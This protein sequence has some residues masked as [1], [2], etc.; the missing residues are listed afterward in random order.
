M[1]RVTIMS[2]A[3][4]ITRGSAAVAE[5]ISSLST[6]ERLLFSQGV[7]QLGTNAW[8]ELAK[9][10]SRHPLM[11]RPKNYFT[12]QVSLLP[13]YLCSSNVALSIVMRANL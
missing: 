5:D 1:S 11:S 2:F 12:A 7:Y 6:S 3:S 13:D 4:R 8:G 9:L 10:L